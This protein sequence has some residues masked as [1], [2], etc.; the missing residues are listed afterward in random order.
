MTNANDNSPRPSGDP[1]LRQQLDV[2]SLEPSGG[3]FAFQKSRA[4]TAIRKIYPTAPVQPLLR[5]KKN[6]RG[7]SALE[8]ANALVFDGPFN[9][10]KTADSMKN[11]DSYYLVEESYQRL[12][13][14][15]GRHEVETGEITCDTNGKSFVIGDD[16]FTK[17]GRALPPTGQQ[18]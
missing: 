3:T 17:Y 9:I 1:V 2:A 15:V 7:K 5:A 4:H 6:S 18:D 11:R 16:K 10:F 12:L 8:W 13:V 14:R